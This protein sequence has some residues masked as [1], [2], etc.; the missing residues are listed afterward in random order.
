MARRWLPVL[1][2]V[3]LMAAAVQVPAAAAPGSTQVWQWANPYPLSNSLQGVVFGG[4]QFVAVGEYGTILTSPD[5]I[6]WTVRESGIRET[7]DGV[8][9][10]GG[11]YVAYGPRA[12]VLTSPDG[13]DWTRVTLPD[14][15]GPV[16]DMAYGSGQFI[17]VTYSGWV[18]SA[19]GAAWQNQRWG[20]GLFTIRRIAF[21][22]G[23]FVAAGESS[24]FVS[25]NGAE[26]SEHLTRYRKDPWDV[27]YTGDRFVVLG[28][29]AVLTSPEGETWQAA[30]LPKFSPKAL[31]VG[32]GRMVAVGTESHI[33][34]SSDGTAWQDVSP[35]PAAVLQSG[36]GM[37][38]WLTGVAYGNGTFVAVGGEGAV[39]T[40]QDGTA[41]KARHQGNRAFLR[42]AAW[43]AGRFVAVGADG[44]VLTSADGHSWA[45]AESGQTAG[46]NGVAFLDGQFFAFGS[47]GLLL[48]SPDGLRW[49]RLVVPTDKS[50]VDGA[51]S[52]SA[53][54]AVGRSGTVLR[55]GDGA[56]WTA[57]SL[58]KD[59]SFSDVAYGSGLFVAVGQHAV[60]TS[61]R[62]WNVNRLIATSP[63][64]LTWTVRVDEWA[65]G[66][67]SIAYGNGFFVAAQEDGTVV[68]SRDGIA[69]SVER[70]AGAPGWIAFDGQMFVGVR[71]A[72]F[73]V[74]GDGLRWTGAPL[75]GGPA[76][77]TDVQ[78][79]WAQT[80]GYLQAAAARKVMQ[81]FPDGSFQPDVPVTRAQLI[82]MVAAAAGLDGAQA[83]SGSPYLDMWDHWALGWVSAAWHDG[84]LGR[85]SPNQIWS[86]EYLRPEE[87]VTRAEAALLLANLIR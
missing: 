87:E 34:F 11:L 6:D 12:F 45:P 81:G 47:A 71:S 21:G 30:A 76:A 10:G 29:D 52:G 38:I 62:S 61:P 44:T 26:W 72:G 31:A 68:R 53:F 4:G 37:K 22:A 70:N 46:L 66:L 28:V 35:D 60:A 16:Q 73:L 7:L 40:S 85:E 15:A 82:K 8:A 36:A 43:G 84:L 56:T 23:R 78:D 33:F 57:Q 86:G 19:D 51:Y 27:V 67:T 75:P 69:W 83:N 74:S 79:H 3:L 24:V 2:A 65:S 58:D 14:G 64:G 42:D 18:R 41:W 25:G 9:Y 63:D 32:A 50:L 80:Q 54:V 49:E 59:L 13:M 17:G 39:Y 55:S 48:R 1:L 5:G 20:D 77:F